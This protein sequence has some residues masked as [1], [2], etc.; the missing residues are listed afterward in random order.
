MDPEILALRT[1]QPGKGG[2]EV[3]AGPQ[4][5]SRMR[6]P[7]GHR[8]ISWS[9]KRRWV[10]LIAPL[11]LVVGCGVEGVVPL[12]RHPAPFPSHAL[13]STFHVP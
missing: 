2:A 1:G 10:G 8:W 11:L 12:L 6:P 9:T 3:L 13:R 7:G 5:A 4:A